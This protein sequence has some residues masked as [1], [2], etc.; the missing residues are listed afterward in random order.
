MP[1]DAVIIGSGPNGLVAAN[2]LADQGWSVQ[3]VEAA[4]APGGAV[5]SAEL[6]EPGFT[7]DLFSA[8]YPLGA[9]SS[10][11]AELGLERHGLRWCHAPLVLAH[12]TADGTCPVLSRN[13][14]E[15]T[16]SLDSYHR[17]DGD[18]WRQMM[19]R[20]DEVS[21]PLVDA[22]MSPFPP[23]RAGARLAASLPVR[24]WARFARFMLLPIRRMAEEEFHSDQA[25]RLLAGLA[26]HTDLG[27]EATLSGMFGWLLGCLGQTVGF[28]VP[29]GGAGALS[30]AMVRR[31]ESAGSSVL[32]DAPV[33]E[34]IV[35]K[36]RAV[37]VRLADGREISAGRAVLADVSAPALYGGLVRAEHLPT[38]LLEDLR[39]F[40]WDN[41]TV[42]VDWT[43]DAPIPWQAEPARRAGTVHVTEG[44]DA[45]TVFA[46]ELARGLVP[47]R[48][49]LLVGQQSMTDPTRQP[50]GRETAWAY[51]HVPRTVRGDSG[52]EISG[53]WDADDE[54]AIVARM[55]AEIELLAPGF[56]STIRGR[57][58]FTPPSFEATDHNLSFGAINGGTTQLHQQLVFRP[59]PGRSR[60]ETPVK[61][62][63]LASASAHPGG[64][65]HGAAGANAAR[66]AIAGDRRARVATAVRRR[67]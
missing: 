43:L 27:P 31:L 9:A 4:D 45:L 2:L 56:G 67:G 19:Q 66:A 57:H 24:E 20:W 28:P 55:E 26:L 10:V 39:R 44:V 53:R 17:G 65:V 6:I 30:M 47:A 52:N 59:L 14:D 25:R 62:L 63:Y 13:I 11:L 35:R 37:A 36:G 38:D 64:G 46:S 23:V 7:N 12:P 58:V 8:F 3:V 51:T 48:P 49:Y 40:H 42:K 5:R 34:V 60:A 33:D 21:G 54:A 15:T 50:A 22:L 29:E 18:A 16:A 1:P 61:D 32:C 41:G